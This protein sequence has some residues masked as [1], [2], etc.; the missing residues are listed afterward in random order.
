MTGPAASTRTDSASMVASMI[1]HVL[2]IA[3][4]ALRSVQEAAGGA[5][6]IVHSFLMT[7]AGRTLARRQGVPDVSAQFFP[8]FLPT[9]AFPAVAEQVVV[10]LCAFR[11]HR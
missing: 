3:G 7:D 11:L 4:A 9:A 6:L 5:D 8:I 1:R 2:P 10:H